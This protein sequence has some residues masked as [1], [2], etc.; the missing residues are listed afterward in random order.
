MQ[1]TETGLEVLVPH[2][3]V[4]VMSGD[5]RAMVALPDGTLVFAP[6][7]ALLRAYRPR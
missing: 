6:N 7:N 3:H 1:R 2:D 4:I 5:F